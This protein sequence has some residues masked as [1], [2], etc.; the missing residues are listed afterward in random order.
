[1]K[2]YLA[3][4]AA[5]LALLGACSGDSSLAPP[6]GTCGG[7]SGAVCP[8]D[9]FCD[10][11]NNRCGGDDKE[12]QCKPRPEQCPRLLVPELTCGCDG[13]VYSSACDATLAGTD[14]NEAGSCQVEASSFACGYRQ[15]RKSNEAC[16]RTNSDV[17]GEPDSFS[18]RGL[19]AS[20]GGTPSCGCASGLPCGDRCTGDAGSG[21]TLTCLGG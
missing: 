6:G 1:M 16:T 2:L 10:F 11:G 5:Q 20:C 17:G 21:L 13:T 12:G 19:P 9:E 15:C 7:R 4:L 14:L 18:C 3:I 8:A